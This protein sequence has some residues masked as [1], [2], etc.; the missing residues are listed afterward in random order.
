MSRIAYTANTLA[1][2]R[3]AKGQRCIEF[4]RMAGSPGNAATQRS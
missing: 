1:V 4:A 2:L 3:E